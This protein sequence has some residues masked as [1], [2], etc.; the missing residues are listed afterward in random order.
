MNVQTKATKNVNVRKMAIIGVL[1]AVSIMMSMI[2][3]IGYIP[4]GPTNATIMHVPV[5]IG[6]I[7]E[8]PIVGATVGFIFGLTSL[9]KALTQPT[10]TSFAFI[11]P[12][13]S[14]LPRVLIGILAYYIYEFAMKLTKKAS[15]SGLLAG[16]LGSIINTAGV[17]GMI[18]I[19]YGARFAE[20]SGASAST[21][22]TFIFTLAATNGIPEAIIGALVVS[23]VIMALKKVIKR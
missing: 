10:I 9:I 11:N 12:L 19:L 14:I 8:G 4:I 13:V 7:I 1:S 3:G 6:S 23:P 2:P 5:I 20:V 16:G 15:I 21:A 17:L 18:Y 22:G